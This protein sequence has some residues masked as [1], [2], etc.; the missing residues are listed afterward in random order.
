MET[1]LAEAHVLVMRDSIINYQDYQGIE[2]TGIL[3]FPS[4]IAL[5]SIELK[6]PILSSMA[7]MGEI[8]IGGTMIK[9]DEL[10][11]AL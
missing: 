1:E 2:M 3:A 5:C 7:V 8:S 4:F 11:N 10:A 9:V 6:R